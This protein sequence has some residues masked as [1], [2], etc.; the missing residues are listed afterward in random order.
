MTPNEIC[1]EYFAAASKEELKSILWECTSFPF[2]RD[3][4]EACLRKQLKDIFEKSGGN[5]ETAI[6]IAHEEMNE[7]HEDMKCREIMRI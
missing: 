1:R 3:D 7:A 4:A 2:F 5:V 6:R